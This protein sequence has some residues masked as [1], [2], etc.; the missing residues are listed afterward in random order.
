MVARVEGTVTWFNEQKGFGFLQ[1]ADGRDVLVQ[2]DEIERDGFRTLTVGERVSFELDAEGK[3]PRAL[4][5][6]PLA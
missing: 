1:A 3:A 6:R 4:R 2:Y 5:V